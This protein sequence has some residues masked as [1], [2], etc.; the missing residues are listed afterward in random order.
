MKEY[1]RELRVGDY[2]R[3]ELASIIR[4]EMR[5][6]RVGIVS[7]TDVRVSTD[8][9]TARVY[10]ASLGVDDTDQREELLSVLNKAG[11]FLRSAVARQNSMRTTPRLRF[12]YDELI[13][14]GARMETL[15]DR[16][17]EKDIEQG[18]DAQVSGDS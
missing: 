13:E 12:Y 10:V 2:L 1:G 9:S 6:P 3:R 17:V 8:L 16:A 14:E 7:V 11:G 5:D 4:S 18:N 15:I